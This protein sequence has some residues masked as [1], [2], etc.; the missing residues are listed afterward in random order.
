MAVTPFTQ[1]EMLTNGQLH[2][3]NGI[4]LDAAW[5]SAAAQER[6]RAK[7][8]TQRAAQ[9]QEQAARYATMLRSLGMDPDTL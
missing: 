5:Q 7:E 8:A 4:A 6:T 3:Q 2:D 9:A 1:K